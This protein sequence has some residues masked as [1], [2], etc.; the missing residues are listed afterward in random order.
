MLT[1]TSGALYYVDFVASAIGVPVNVEEWCIDLGLLGTQKCLSLPP[2]LSIIT[3]SPKAWKVIE[4]VNY[5]GEFNP[6]T[7]S[8]FGGYDALKPWKDVVENK[9]FPYT[10]NWR[11][12][13]ALEFTLTKLEAEGFDKVH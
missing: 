12:I 5:C 4:N 8:K 6:Y 7:L 1:L 2:D 13:A 10:H 11:A 9:Y 3:V